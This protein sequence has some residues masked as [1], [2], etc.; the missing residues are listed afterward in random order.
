MC[1]L[2]SLTLCNLWIYSRI[3]SVRNCMQCMRHR[4]C[5]RCMTVDKEEWWCWCWGVQSRVWWTFN[6]ST[7]RILFLGEMKK[8]NENWRIIADQL[9]FVFAKERVM[10]SKQIIGVWWNGGFL[11]LIN[12]WHGENNNNICLL[13]SIYWT[14]ST[15]CWILI[16]LW[17]NQFLESVL[18]NMLL[19]MDKELILI[20]IYL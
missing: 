20:W 6:W 17:V 4:F 13:Y 16:R 5:N 2:Q 18:A 14:S 15:D 9:L 8:E 1:V 7:G 12:E 19:E 3:R 11:G 10:M